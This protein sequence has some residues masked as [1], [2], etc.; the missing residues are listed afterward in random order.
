M[1]G[2]SCCQSNKPGEKKGYDNRTPASRHG[3]SHTRF[4]SGV[5]LAFI[6]REL[7]HHDRQYADASLAASVAQPAGGLAPRDPELVEGVTNRYE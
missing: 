1:E 3:S 2:L 7:V 5:N 6:L 4:F